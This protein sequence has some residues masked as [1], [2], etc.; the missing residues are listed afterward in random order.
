MVDVVSCTNL[1][2]EQLDGIYYTCCGLLFI[3]AMLSFYIM[4]ILTRRMNYG[5]MK[6]YRRKLR[7]AEFFVQVIC[8]GTIFVA[9][10]LQDVNNSQW[11]IIGFCLFLICTDIIPFLFVSYIMVKRIKA[12]RQSNKIDADADAALSQQNS[13]VTAQLKESD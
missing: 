9:N 13:I 6:S 8:I 5:V 10:V 2:E 12:Y 11:Y 3:Y 7:F 1:T 4:F